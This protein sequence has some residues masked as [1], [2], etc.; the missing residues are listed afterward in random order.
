MKK[1]PWFLSRNFVP[2]GFNHLK[3]ASTK[4]KVDF[5]V[6]VYQQAPAIS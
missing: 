2:H 6:E 3:M 1:I 5:E 4:P